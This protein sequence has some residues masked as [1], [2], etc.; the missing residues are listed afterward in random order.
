MQ[1]DVHLHDIGGKIR[2][3]VCMT[4]VDNKCDID[5]TKVDIKEVVMAKLEPC[6]ILLE[7]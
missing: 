7:L 4:L 6:I 1:K 5:S 3:Y 2:C